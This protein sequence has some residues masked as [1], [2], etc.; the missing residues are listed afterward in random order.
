MITCYAQNKAPLLF[1]I[2][3]S[4]H[5]IIIV[6]INNIIINY[7]YSSF[8]KALFLCK[9]FCSLTEVSLH[10]PGVILH[11]LLKKLRL[12]EFKDPSVNQLIT[13]TTA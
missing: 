7:N 10:N 1:L 12:R 2:P 6:N 13:K 4:L 3:L 5:R 8:H 11:F 9:A